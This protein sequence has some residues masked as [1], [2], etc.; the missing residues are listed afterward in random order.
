MVKPKALV[1]S[2]HGD[3]LGFPFRPRGE[4]SSGF[5]SVTGRCPL[6]ICQSNRLEAALV[7]G[8]PDFKLRSE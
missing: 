3:R 1:R 7:A 2:H 4:T 5:D 6:S 8:F